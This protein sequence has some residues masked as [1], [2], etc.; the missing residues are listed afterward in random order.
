M[1]VHISKVVKYVVLAAQPCQYQDISFEAQLV[2]EPG[3]DS[4]DI[5]NEVHSTR[6]KKSLFFNASSFPQTIL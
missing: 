6:H 2:V 3:K 5:D 1:D 4:T